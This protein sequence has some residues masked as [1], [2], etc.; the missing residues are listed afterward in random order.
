[1][2]AR[3][4]FS[5]LILDYL[6]ERRVVDQQHD[7]QILK[8]VYMLLDSR[9]GVKPID[10]DLMHMLD[11]HGTPYQLVLTKTD[12]MPK[13]KLVDSIASVTD[14]AADKD[15]VMCYP[16]IHLVSCSHLYGL[17]DLKISIATAC[18]L[19][20]REAFEGGEE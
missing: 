15:H 1:M 13:K 16:E 5:D 10:R 20:S 8:R 7:S 17:H 12:C 9:H 4:Q 11:H 3:N 2:S 6:E 18:E 14:I 19:I